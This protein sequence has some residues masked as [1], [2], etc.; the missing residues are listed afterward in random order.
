MDLTEE[1][2]KDKIRE[3][4]SPFAEQ[5]ALAIKMYDQ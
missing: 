4:I 3:R 1:E 2:K 5:H